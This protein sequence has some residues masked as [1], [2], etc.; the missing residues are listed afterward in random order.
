MGTFLMHDFFYSR[1]ESA[2]RDRVRAAER[3][4][5]YTGKGNSHTYYK[6]VLID[7]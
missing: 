3:D 6:T 1:F 2:A 5:M 7:E 4:D